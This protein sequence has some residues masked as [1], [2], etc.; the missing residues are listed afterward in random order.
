[1][2]LVSPQSPQTM[3]RTTLL[4]L[5]PGVVVMIYIF[6]YGFGFNLILCT[7]AALVS[8]AALLKI[9][10]IPVASATDMSALLTGVLIAL[11]LPPHLPWWIPV[12]TSLF[13]IVIGKHAYGGLGN[14]IFNPAML[15]YCIALVAWPLHLTA[16]P[17]AQHLGADF[18]SAGQYLMVYDGEILSEALT[19]ATPLEAWR[20]QQA[21]PNTITP[22]PWDMINSAFLAGGIWLLWKKTIT[23]QIPLSLLA[24]LALTAWV[25]GANIA[26]LEMH[27]LSG[28]TMLGAFFIATD[29]VT[30]PRSVVGKLLFGAAIGILLALI[31]GLGDYADGL[32]FAVLMMN[33]AVPLL[34]K[35]MPR[36]AP[37]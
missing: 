18:A 24:A 23:W 34:D 9:R 20:M 10:S 30:S 2:A 12:L 37:K 29:P 11:A 26:T 32:A 35:V 28:A 27:L 3:M 14:N 5:S 7:T 4:A 8:E 1:M 36:Y 19:G 17:D 13:A 25:M 16:W 6:G 31:R 22:I 33:A 21:I 15:G